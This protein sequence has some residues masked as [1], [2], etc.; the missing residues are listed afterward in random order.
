MTT[1]NASTGQEAIEAAIAAEGFIQSCY[2]ISYVWFK[3]T[4]AVVAL[5]N[6]PDWTGTAG[7]GAYDAPVV[8]V[9]E[10]VALRDDEDRL[11]CAVPGDEVQPNEGRCW[12]LGDSGVTTAP[13]A[14]TAGA[15]ALVAVCEK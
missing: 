8:R 11:V 6:G 13:A 5:D 2:G 14:M 1:Y 15:A 10:Y 7:T 9:F 3:T 4:S 12:A